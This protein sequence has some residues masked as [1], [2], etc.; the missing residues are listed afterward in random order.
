MT[1]AHRELCNRFI[2]HLREDC[3]DPNAGSD[4]VR[5]RMLNELQSGLMAHEEERLAREL[6]RRQRAVAR[7]ELLAGLFRRKDGL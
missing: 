2:R 1:A 7:R 6:E 5:Q 4:S 3:A